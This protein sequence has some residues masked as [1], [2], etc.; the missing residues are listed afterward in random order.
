VIKKTFSFTGELY[1][2]Q[3]RVRYVLFLS[4]K[5]NLAENDFGGSSGEDFR[6]SHPAK[7]IGKK[8]KKNSADMCRKRGPFLGVRPQVSK[9]ST[10]NI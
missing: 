1:A 2:Y 3:I 7:G 8:K 4:G 9:G 10:G 5:K 6:A